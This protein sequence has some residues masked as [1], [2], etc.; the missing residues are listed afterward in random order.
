MDP[1]TLPENVMGNPGNMFSA[2]ATVTVFPMELVAI[3]TVV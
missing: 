1:K 3:A 2:D